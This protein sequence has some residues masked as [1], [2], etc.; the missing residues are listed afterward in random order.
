MNGEPG[1]PNYPDNFAD[2]PKSL[3]DIRSS[4]TNDGADWTPRECL[5][6]MLR[7][8]D[9]GEIDPQTLIII[10]ARVSDSKSDVF[11]SLSSPN[12]LMTLGAMDR[13]RHRMNWTMDQNSF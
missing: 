9:S 10:A 2:Y 12:A 7:C 11:Y 4:R 5:I 6:D 3:N 1:K 8:I 13:A